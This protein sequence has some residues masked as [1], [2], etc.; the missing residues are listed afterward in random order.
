ML[1]LTLR[2]L[3]NLKIAKNFM[4]MTYNIIEL[5]YSAEKINKFFA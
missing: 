2:L 5:R 3:Q 4:Y 1:Y